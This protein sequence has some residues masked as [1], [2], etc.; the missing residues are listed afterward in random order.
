VSDRPR[1]IGF[2]RAALHLGGLWALAFAQPLFDLLG[3]NAQ[4]FVARGSTTGDI[5]VLA[6]AYTLVPPLAGAVLVWALGRIRPVAG[7]VVHLVLVAALVAALALPPLGDVLGGS[8]AAIAAA[9]VVGAGAAALYARAEPA[10]SFLT[11]LSPAPL[12]VLAL[13]LVVSPVRELIVPAGDGGSLAGPTRSSTPIVHIVLDE[14]AVTT[15][16]A[17]DGT[18]DAE[19]FPN[20]AKLAR[21]ATWY[22]NATTVDDL[23]A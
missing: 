12:V 22:R 18:I 11:V 1:S 7:W 2:R 17:G 21:D 5:L 13:F 10:R 23:T 20:L 9:A 15:I 16:D 8:A 4:F 3:R 19:L 14:L 6:F